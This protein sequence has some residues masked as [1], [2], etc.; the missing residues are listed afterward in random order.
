LNPAGYHWVNILLHAINALL[1]WRLLK[2]LGVPGAWLAA[3]LFALHPVQVESV[4][5]ITELKSV[6][7]LFFVLLTLFCWV[8]FVGNDPGDLVLA[9]AG[10]LRAG[11][12]QQNDSL[13]PAG[14]A[15]FDSVAENQTD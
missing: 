11:T 7:S 14:G 15:A 12:L 8:E 10:G 9:G 1:V 4:A 6:L 13:H 2:R 5:W 3:A